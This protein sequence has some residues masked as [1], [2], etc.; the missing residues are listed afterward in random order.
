M[1]SKGEEVL[2]AVRRKS[3]EENM[4]EGWEDLMGLIYGMRAPYLKKEFKP[5]SIR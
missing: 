4:T 5:D 3:N 2:N 1:V